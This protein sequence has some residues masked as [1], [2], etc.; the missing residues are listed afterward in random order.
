MKDATLDL[1]EEHRGILEGLKILEALTREGKSHGKVDG[2]DLVRLIEFFKV[3]AD[4]CHHGK[5]ESL[6]FPHLMSVHVGQEDANVKPLLEEH[7]QGRKLIQKIE[8]TIKKNYRV[9][10]IE[11][12]PTAEQ[13]IKLLRNHI[14]KEDQYLLPKAKNVLSSK[15][16][17]ALIRDFNKFEDQVMG[18]GVHE[19]FH[20]MLASFKQKYQIN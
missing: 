12:I 8:K 7:T 20:L 4:K 11:F 17:E 14:E 6:L 9:D 2:K 10:L 5:E 1:Y 13:Y 3:F 18:K 15:D 16:Q 19:R